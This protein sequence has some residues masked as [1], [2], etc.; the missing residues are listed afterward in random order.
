MFRF[1][2]PRG[3]MRP[4]THRMEESN[5]AEGLDAGI[6]LMALGADNG[7]QMNAKF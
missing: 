5:P 1:M 4:H 2:T 7:S 3:A 6:Y